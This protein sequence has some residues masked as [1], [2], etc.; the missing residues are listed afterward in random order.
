MAIFDTLINEIASKFGLGNKAGP[1]VAQVLQFMASDRGGLSG[2]FDRFKAAGLEGL[3]SSMVGSKDPQPMPAQQ[4]EAVF[5]KSWLEGL[6]SKLGLGSSVVTPALGFVVPK[7]IGMLSPDGRVPTSVPPA[8]QGFIDSTLRAPAAEPVRRAAAPPPPAAGGGLPKWLLWLIPLLI[9]GGLLW[10]LLSGK[11]E[12]VA[13]QA[14]APAVVQPTTPAPAVQPATKVQPR[15]G[16]NYHGDNYV[17]YSGVVKDEASRTSIIDTLKGVF[18]AGNVFGE[19]KVD[20]NAEAATWL[21]KLKAAIENFKIPGLSALF[22]GSSINV[23]GLIPDVDRDRILEALKG[24]FGSGFSLAALEEDA[25]TKA[26]AQIRGLKAGFG[27]QD[28]IGALNATVINFATG[29]AEVPS[30]S[31]A[32]LKE[33]AS[34]M[35]QLPPNTVIEIGGHTDSTGDAAANMQLSQAR[36]EAVRIVLIEEG[37]APSMLTAKGYGSTMPKASN[38]TAEG[39]YQNRR[40]EYTVGQ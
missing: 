4:V 19:I 3:L 7:L 11:E 13:V 15:L 9:I 22:G 33:A 23:G 31:R 30:Y 16:V 39:R 6:M 34:V 12:K 21:D 27:A 24:V 8:W 28:V 35:K 32:V 14:P 18:G 5:G 1:L 37:V 17:T 40:I 2:F 25:N 29:K 10:S 36:A 20:P 38:E 26:L